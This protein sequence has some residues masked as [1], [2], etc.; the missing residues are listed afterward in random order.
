MPDEA[1]DLLA[2]AKFSF[3]IESKKPLDQSG[4]K[5]Y[6]GAAMKVTT[7][8]GTL[9]ELRQ[10]GDW[11]YLRTDPKALEKVAGEPMPDAKELPPEAGAF[12][13][14]LEGKWV[15]F[16][17]KDAEKAAGETAGGPAGKPSPE[18]TLDAK[19]QEKLLDSLRKVVANEV[20]FATGKNADGTEHITATAPFRTLVTELVGELRPLAKEL[21][22]GMD[23]PTDKELKEAPDAKVTADFALKN[24]ELKEVRVDLA[25]LAED[26]KVKKFGLVMR[27]GGGERPTA[28]AGAKELDI[29]GLMQGMF[30]GPAMDGAEF[31]EG[32]LEEPGFEDPVV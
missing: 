22:T 3:T 28:P 24:G 12:K 19:T 7:P 5:D 2:G 30:A 13:D 16:N 9:A 25:K 6:T 10:V 8:E 23:L 17:T 18:P 14:V 4:E 15:K 27:I 21:P 11:A 20:D 32:G 26:A 1:A 29:A 31:E